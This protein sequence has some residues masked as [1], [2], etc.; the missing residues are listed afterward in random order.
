MS[1]AV[2]KPNEAALRTPAPVPIP[3]TITPPSR[4]LNRLA[5][6]ARFLRN[7]LLVV[8]QAVY[9]QDLVRLGGSTPV[10]W[11]TEPNLIKAVLLDEREKFQKLAQIRILGPLLGKGILTSEGADW[12][13]QRQS[14]APMFRHQ[15][16]MT[17]VPALRARHPASHREVAAAAVGLDARDR[18]GHDARHF[19][20][21]FGN[22]AAV[23]R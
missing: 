13:W 12:K 5:F 20:R 4:P 2:L 14:S 11:V 23:R 9:E 8:P 17:F 3:S 21:H 6:F 1:Q 10:A 7:P 22:A 18:A 16:L 15:E 19:R